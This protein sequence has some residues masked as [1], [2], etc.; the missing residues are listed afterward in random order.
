MSRYHLVTT[1]RVPGTLE[2]VAGILAEVERLPL[3]WPAVYLSA[4][5]TATG[6]ERGLGR[7]VALHTRGWLPYTL[8]WSFRVV[9]IDPP[10]RVVIEPAGD[11]LGRGTWTFAQEGPVAVIR[12]DWEV[13][14]R[15]PLLRAL[16]WL[17]KPVFAAN[18]G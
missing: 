2:E 3:W 5:Q 10:R 13:E 6:D 11:F 15:K 12:Y 8:R 4:R 18:H 1:W 16:G 14:A 17:L 7:E 9:E